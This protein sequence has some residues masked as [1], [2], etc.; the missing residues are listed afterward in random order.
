VTAPFA[1]NAL[2]DPPVRVQWHSGYGPSAAT[3]DTLLGNTVSLPAFLFNKTSAMDDYRL[4]FVSGYPVTTGSTT[5]G[6]AAITAS[7]ATG[8]I[9]TTSTLTPAASCAQEY[10]ALT[11]FAVARDFARAQDNKMVAGYFGDTSGQVHRFLLAGGI[12]RAQ[13]L[14]CDH[15]LHFSPTV[16]QLDRDAV[17][18]SFAHEIF[19][20]QVTNSNLDR[21]TAAL[22][23]SKMVF[24]KEIVQTD[25]NG[26]VT[27]V[28]KDVNWG[29]SGQITLTVGVN[30]QICGVTQTDTNGV[31]TCQNPMPST[32]RPT[33]T[34]VGVLL[35][36]AS[37]FQVMTTWYVPAADGCTRGQSYLTVHQMTGGGTATQRVGAMVA[38]EPVT[39]PVMLGG[40]IYIF[41]SSGA[42][43]IT[44]LIPD[45]VTPGRAVPPEASGTAQFKQL[46]WWEVL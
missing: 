15:P 17:T 38:S 43:D 25:T 30:D 2:A 18:S 46:A 44:K 5:Q 40:R 26:V 1:S 24:W 9:R 21:D 7:A 11:D 32:A 10:T 29:T 19:P 6:R 16:V 33:S 4:A 31:V 39:S 8:A 45:S 3:Y 13:S 20:V 23:P 34:P 35:R 27:D 36:D 28:V 41:G 22:A 14:G 37:G 42:I 12:G